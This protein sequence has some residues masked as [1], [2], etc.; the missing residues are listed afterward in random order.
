VLTC[1]AARQSQLDLEDVISLRVYVPLGFPIGL[2]QF[3]LQLLL[4]NGRSSD[5]SH[6]E[7]EVSLMVGGNIHDDFNLLPLFVRLGDGFCRVRSRVDVLGFFE[8]VRITAYTTLA[9]VFG[10]LDIKPAT[11]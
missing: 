8:M 10:P 5:L 4:G 3:I 2:F 7:H 11:V 9:F 6:T 1:Q